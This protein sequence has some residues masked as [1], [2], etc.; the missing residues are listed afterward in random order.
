MSKDI[1]VIDINKEY[2]ANLNTEKFNDPVEQFKAKFSALQIIKFN[3]FCLKTDI[4]I[5]TDALGP[6]NLSFYKNLS[7]PYRQYSRLT[8]NAILYV[9]S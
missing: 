3:A 1:I 9:A 5:W 7:P 2:R 8:P 4:T 6:H